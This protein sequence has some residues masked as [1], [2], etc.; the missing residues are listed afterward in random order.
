MNSRP[1]PSPTYTLDGSRVFV[2]RGWHFNFLPRA[3]GKILNLRGDNMRVNDLFVPILLLLSVFLLGVFAPAEAQQTWVPGPQT[4]SFRT[5]TEI[6]TGRTKTFVV[7]QRYRSYGYGGGCY[8]CNPVDGFLQSYV[9]GMEA[10]SAI[11]HHGDTQIPKYVPPARP[12][13]SPESARAE[14]GMDR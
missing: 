14:W 13:W 1:R 2:G 5:W 7:P 8:Y 10:A 11:R 6:N 9:R 3:G 4:G 12:T